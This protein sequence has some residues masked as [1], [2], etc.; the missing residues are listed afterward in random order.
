MITEKT[1]AA[2][3]AYTSGGAWEVRRGSI[4]GSAV[5]VKMPRF[6]TTTD[7]EKI[8]EVSRGFSLSYLFSLLLKLF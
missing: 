4:D 1:L 2:E 3:S 7:V 8:R 6:S 5:A